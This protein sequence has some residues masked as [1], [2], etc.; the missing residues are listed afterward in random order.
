MTVPF[1][2]I[3]H[4]LKV[5]EKAIKNLHSY[6]ERQRRIYDK[7]E[8]SLNDNT[9]NHRQKLL[10]G[11]M[12]RGKIQAAEISKQE[13]HHKIS[14][15]TARKDLEALVGAGWLKKVKI[16]RNSYYLKGKKLNDLNEV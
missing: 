8:G 13:E 10:L 5:L 11:D 14:Y 4:Q 9:L 6:M 2:F 12:I 3:L 16:G 7:L 1:Y 15:L